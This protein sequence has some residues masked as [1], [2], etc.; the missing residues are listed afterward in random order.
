MAKLIKKIKCQSCKESILGDVARS[1]HT[2]CPG[3]DEVHGPAVFT[4]FVDNGGLTIPSPSVF[5]VVACA[6]KVFKVHVCKE[7]FKEITAKKQIKKRM[8]LEVVKY[9]W[10]KTEPVKI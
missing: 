4:S 6:E 3:Y 8:I 7:K 5:K 10:E 9:F 1:D 2:Y